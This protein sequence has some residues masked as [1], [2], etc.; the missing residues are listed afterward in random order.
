MVDTGASKTL[1]GGD[2]VTPDD[3]IDGKVTIQ[4]AHGDTVSYP[5]AA[6][7]ITLDGKDIITHAA[8]VD[9]LPV[10]ALLGWHDPELV[11]LVKTDGATKALAAVTSHQLESSTDLPVTRDNAPTE[12]QKL[13]G[14]GAL[15][16]R[17]RRRGASDRDV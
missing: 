12:D 5:L 8:V 3:I 15:Y 11:Q 14:R 17:H 4:C 6:V 9:S 7:K 16:H 13:I 2:L 1:V 10:A